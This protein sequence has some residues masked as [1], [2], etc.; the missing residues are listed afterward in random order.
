MRGLGLW[1]EPRLSVSPQADGVGLPAL[2]QPRVYP[3]TVI[4]RGRL[5]V[6]GHA[7]DLN[8]PLL[9]FDPAL[10]VWEARASVQKPR[11]NMK[12]AALGGFLYAVGGFQSTAVERY[13]LD[14]DR[15]TGCACLSN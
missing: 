7:L 12:G 2:P 5:Y 15:W 10:G 9:R 1:S 4:L 3:A 6:V 13:D 14:T 8:M 11:A